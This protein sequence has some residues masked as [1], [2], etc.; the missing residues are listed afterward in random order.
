[1]DQW[2]AETDAIIQRHKNDFNSST[3]ASYIK[4]AGGYEAYLRSLGGIFARGCPKIR[5]YTSL[6]DCCEYVMGLMAIWGFDY[7][8]GDSEAS[9]YHRWGNGAADRFYLSGRG[10]CNGGT[11]SQLCQGTGGRDR[12]TCCNYG[13]DTLLKAGGVYRMASERYKGMVNEGIAKV[14][15]DKDKLQPGDLV[16]FFSSKVTRDKATWK[17]WRH[18]AIVLRID[19]SGPVLADFGSRFIKTKKPYHA[20]SEYRYAGWIGLHVYNLED[21]TMITKSEADRAVELHREIK[22]YLDAK[23]AEY[24]PAVYDLAQIYDKDKDA[25]L[26]AAADYVLDDHAGRGEARKAFFGSEYDEVQNNVN[27]VLQLAQDVIDG[28][29]G[30]GEDRRKALGADYDIVQKQVER[31]LKLRKALG[32]GG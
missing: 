13:I 27:R 19:G 32:I 25:Y 28:K 30:N 26:R 16:H 6:R 1:M 8:N 10:K 24:G 15:M 21:D 14:V 7:S 2:R 29:Y 9:H 22:S 12:T 5:S 18:V 3:Y 4:A 31:I 20:W 11:I 23:K 17:N